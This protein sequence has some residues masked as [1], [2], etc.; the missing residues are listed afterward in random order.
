MD[1]FVAYQAFILDLDPD[2]VRD[3]SSLRRAMQG[4]LSLQDKPTEHEIP[5]ASPLLSTKP[6]LSSGSQS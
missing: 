5:D 3:N 1:G 2:R 6:R 4:L